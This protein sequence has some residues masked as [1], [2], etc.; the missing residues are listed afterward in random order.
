MLRRRRGI[1]LILAL[2]TTA[3]LV[4]LSVSFLVLAMGESRNSRTASYEGAAVQA[5]NFGIGFVIN[6]MGRGGTV[7][8]LPNV[9]GAGKTIWTTASPIASPSP[10]PPEVFVNVLREPVR[11][12]HPGGI[13][14]P[15]DGFDI[16]VTKIPGTQPGTLADRGRRVALANITTGNLSLIPL[17]NDLAFTVYVDVVPII[18][19]GIVSYQLSAVSEIYPNPQN[20]GQPLARR[21]IEVRVLEESAGSYLHFVSNARSTNVQGQ[22]G[23]EVDQTPGSQSQILLDRSK[24]LAVNVVIPPDYVENGPMRVDGQLATGVNTTNTF[25]NASG[26][27][28]FGPGTSS[29]EHR[30]RFEEP[31]TINRLLNEYADG[32]VDDST[33]GFFS[34]GINVGTATLGLP[35]FNRAKGTLKDVSQIATQQ[36]NKK[37]LIEWPTSSLMGG[38]STPPQF[39]GKVPY[40]PTNPTPEDLAYVGNPYVERLESRIVEGRDVKVPIAPDLRPRFPNTEINIVNDQVTITNV[41]TLDGSQ[42][43][44]PQTFD[45]KQFERGVLYVEGGNAVITGGQNVTGQLTI[46]ATERTEDPVQGKTGRERPNANIINATIPALENGKAVPTKSP[47]QATYIDTFNDAYNTTAAVSNDTIYALAARQLDDYNR[48]LAQSISVR[49]GI[50]HDERQALYA[51]VFPPPYTIDQLKKAKEAGII[52]ANVPTGPVTRKLFPP[53]S[54][55]LSPKVEREGNIIMAGDFN[56]NKQDRSTSVGFLAQNFVLLNDRTP[57]DNDKKLTI[58]GVLMSGERSVQLDWDNTGRQPTTAHQQL[59]TPGYNGTLV[60]KG[61]IVGEHIDVDGDYDKRGYFLQQFEHDRQLLQQRPPY[62][63]RWD[64]E[65]LTGPFRFTITHYVDR[66]TLTTENAAPSP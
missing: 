12:R 18:S 31:L 9:V 20:N 54:T 60:L 6:Y 15:Q 27:L 52:T 22:T 17:G 25:A 10:L 47:Y 37:G 43:N 11:F 8:D 40:N 38:G 57:L 44:P 50:R 51:N 14:R 63:P 21:R 41:S 53:P 61:S 5:A 49:Q 65:R 58:N 2:F 48:N 29:Q 24:I 16:N 34:G 59:I 3:I 23:G 45:I 30:P 36:G 35:D 64:F 1:A 7:P 42:L 66:G 62:F 55:L 56:Y 26:H 46:V 4:I 28:G 39:Y 32:G 13:K 33:S 19:R